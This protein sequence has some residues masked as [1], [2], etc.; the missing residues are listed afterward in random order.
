MVV[1]RPSTS[2]QLNSLLT[3]Q[4]KPPYVQQTAQTAQKSVSLF[5]SRPLPKSTWLLDWHEP[6]TRASGGVYPEQL[7]WSALSWSI[8]TAAKYSFLTGKEN[9]E[10]H[11]LHQ[12]MKVRTRCG[13]MSGKDD[14][15]QAES[16]SEA[17]ISLKDRE[18]IEFCVWKMSKLEDYSSNHTACYKFTVK[19][20]C[21]KY[22]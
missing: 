1:G 4:S 7:A 21:K 3:A 9:S 14:A 17:Q 20:D 13:L 6:A 2:G 15:P 11:P 5:L 8:A 18:L 19:F 16:P 12:E 10:C 22:W